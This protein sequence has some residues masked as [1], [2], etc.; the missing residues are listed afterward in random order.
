VLTELCAFK[1]PLTATTLPPRLQEEIIFL[2]RLQDLDPF[3]DDARLDSAFQVSVPD[4][5]E[6]DRGVIF[7]SVI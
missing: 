6:R 7:N 5:W 2:P 3:G 1:P 4:C